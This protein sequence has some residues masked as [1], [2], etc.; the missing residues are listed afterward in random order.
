M[1]KTLV[2]VL[3][4]F[5]V[6]FSLAGAL[7]AVAATEEVTVH[8]WDFENGTASAWAKYQD[9][10]AQFT[11]GTGTA[12]SDA[13]SITH[14]YNPAL[15]Y[16]WSKFP[17]IISPTAGYAVGEAT[18]LAFDFYLQNPTAFSGSLQLFA[19]ITSPQYPDNW[20]QLQQSQNISFSGGTT[21]GNL[22]KYSFSLPLTNPSA[23]TMQPTDSISNVLFVIP[24]ANTN[25]SNP[26]LID[27][28][29]FVKYEEGEQA[30]NITKFAAQGTAVKGEPVTLQ[31][32]AKGGAAP[33]QYAFY[34]LREG[35]VPFKSEIYSNTGSF[36]FTPTEAGDYRI[37]VYVRDTL[38]TKVKAELSLSVLNE[39][40]PPPEYDKLIALTFDDGSCSYTD[41]LLS[42]LAAKDV[43]AT[44]YI[45]GST[46][47]YY[48]P[49]LLATYNAGHQI[50]NH[51]WTHSSLTTLNQAQ[52][53]SEI[54]QTSD[55]IYEVT[56]TRPNTYRP[57][58]LAIDSNVLNTFS[59]MAAIGCSL[60][61][62]DWTGIST[63]AIIDRIVNGAQDGDIVLLHEI[64]PNTIAA[65]GSI[66]DGLRAK[67]F[68]FVTVNELF[69]AKGKALNGGVYYNSTR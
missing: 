28:V 27:N 68:G 51:T 61:S 35:T 3:A 46:S 26:I 20:F 69:A 59:S 44:F 25:Y 66:I 1:K 40:P 45:V 39:T 48:K 34:V 36:T 52:M 30:L 60:D 4:I 18:H 33:Y 67:G 5:M 42:T 13:L 7:P 54:N 49:Q 14:S 29:R 64:Q 56:G 50:G 10:S 12:E 6:L 63:Q 9:T 17:I 15:A 31:C 19:V 62:Q 43:K 2:G 55:L 16:D 24:G 57:P 37:L 41:T 21:V 23:Q 32:T 53:L 65:V 22:K 47:Q 8:G 58:N 11:L 38:K